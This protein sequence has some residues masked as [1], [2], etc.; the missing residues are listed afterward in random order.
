MPSYKDDIL[1]L[2]QYIGESRLIKYDKGPKDYEKIIFCFVGRWTPLKGKDILIKSFD[3]MISTKK[4][5]MWIITPN[6]NIKY[7]EKMT[8]RKSEKK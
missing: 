1:F 5:E 2:P 4:V 7:L 3:D 8:F 6:K